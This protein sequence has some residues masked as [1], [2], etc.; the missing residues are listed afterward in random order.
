M[1]DACICDAIRTP[2]A[3]YG[4]V[5]AADLAAIPIAIGSTL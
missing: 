5:R 2:F 1:T 3:C 4:G